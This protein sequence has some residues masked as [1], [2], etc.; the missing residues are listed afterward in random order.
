MI[1]TDN[2]TNGLFSAVTQS[3]ILSNYQLADKDKSSQNIIYSLI[4]KRIN[5][6]NAVSHNYYMQN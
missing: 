1:F 5:Y 4:P 6:T 3:I 2:R